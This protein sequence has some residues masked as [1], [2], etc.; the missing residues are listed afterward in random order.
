V[1][2]STFIEPSRIVFF[3]SS[4]NLD[5]RLTPC[6][7]L[8]DYQLTQVALV[9][10]RGATPN[11]RSVSTSDILRLQRREADTLA[12]EAVAARRNLGKNRRSLIGRPTTTQA[13]NKSVSHSLENT[14]AAAASIQFC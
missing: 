3:F 14:C 10:R 13:R 2:P 12:R 8:S 5:D 6:F 7:S 11:S 4:D 9:S 1:P